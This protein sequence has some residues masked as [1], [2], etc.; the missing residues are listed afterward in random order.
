MIAEGRAGRISRGGGQVLPP[1]LWCAGPAWVLLL[2]AACG[3][4]EPMFRE[5]QPFQIL[6]LPAWSGGEVRVTSAAFAWSTALP[7]VLIQDTAVA[8]TRLDS[9]T[10]L[11]RLP[12]ASGTL[13]LRVQAPGVDAVPQ[14]IQLVGLD[15]TWAGPPLVSLP[16]V[17]P[18]GSPVPSV[19][20]IADRHLVDLDLRFSTMSQVLPEST[21]DARCMSAPGLAADPNILVVATASDSACGPLEA[22]TIR[23]QPSVVDSGP[24]FGYPNPYY[25]SALYVGPGKWLLSRMDS[26]ILATRDANGGYAHTVFPLFEATRFKVSPRGDRALPVGGRGSVPVF[27]LPS[28]EVAYTIEGKAILAAAFSEGGD[29]LFVADDTGGLQVRDATTG[30]QLGTVLVPASFGIWDIV[31]DEGRPWLY[32]LVSY[33][34][35]PSVFVVDRRTLTIAGRFANA[36]GAEVAGENFWRAVLSPAERRLYVV[37][38]N[39]GPPS[40]ILEYSLLP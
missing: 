29:T 38:P 5:P 6:G 25:Q 9:I 31:V 3:P 37:V 18:A 39:F 35:S 24:A 10:V 27:D 4:N 23:P 32:A 12:V 28:G 17:W 15:T 34:Y 2:V 13:A 7:T 8:V 1:W 40:W 33:G 22:W 16:E 21:V 26:I 30:N 19:V 11:V 20:A 14:D 36:T